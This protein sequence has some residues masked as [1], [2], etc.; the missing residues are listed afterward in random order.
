MSAKQKRR[1][2]AIPPDQEILTEEQGASFLNFKSGKTLYA[3][4]RRENSEGP[5]YI[6]FPTGAIRYRRADLVAW[7]EALLVPKRAA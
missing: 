6:K 1:A 5:P 3:M 4:R 7:V 2:G